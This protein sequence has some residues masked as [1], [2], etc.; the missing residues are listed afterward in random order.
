MKKVLLSFG[1]LVL[2]SSQQSWAT[3][4]FNQASGMYEETK[5]E[6]KDFSPFWG[7]VAIHGGLLERIRF[8]GHYNAT[9][10]QQGRSVD[11]PQ[12]KIAELIQVLFPSRD[13]VQFV[14]NTNGN[15]TNPAG[16]LSR[17][18]KTINYIIEI[19]I[20]ASDREKKI[21]DIA[22][23][24]K[25][26][27][28]NLKAKDKTA[29]ATLLVSAYEAQQALAN[30][31]IP[32][33]QLYPKNIV[34]ISLLAYFCKVADQKEDLQ[35]LPVLMKENF[36]TSNLF[37]V[38]FDAQTYFNLR[39]AG[40]AHLTQMIKSSDRERIFLMAKGHD[41][42]EN[43]ILDGINY[44]GDTFYK[45]TIF[46]D[47]GETSL[48]NVLMAFLGHQGGALSVEVL[49]EVWKKITP[50][51]GV[52]LTS[53][54]IPFQRM[55]RF[56]ES[57]P[58]ITQ[59]STQQVHEDWAKVVADLNNGQPVTNF[60]DVQY[61]R[62]S[63][64]QIPVYEIKSNYSEDAPKGI[65]NM[66]NVVAKLI[67]DQILN[68][69]W[70]NEKGKRFKQATQKLNRLCELF[71]RNGNDLSWRNQST[72]NQTIDSP[73]PA[74]L[75]T[76][77]SQPVYEWKFIAGHFDFKKVFSYKDDWRV[78]YTDRNFFENEWIA[79]LFPISPDSF[80]R[81]SSPDQ[82]IPVDIVYNCFLKSYYG[83]LNTINLV[84]SNHL[85]QFGPL[86]SRWIDLSI[87]FND[88]YA[89]KLISYFL[90]PWTRTPAVSAILEDPK[91]SPISEL[92]ATIDGRESLAKYYDVVGYFFKEINGQYLLEVTRNV[93]SKG[94][95]VNAVTSTKET[96]LHYVT[97]NIRNEEDRLE[98]QNLLLQAGANVNA[99]DIYDQTPLH[100][101][102][103]LP[104]VETFLKAGADVNAKTRSDET[105]L[106]TAV[107]KRNMNLVK[108]FLKAGAN[109][110]T[111]DKKRM[112]PLAKAVKLG[113]KDITRMLLQAGANPNH[114]IN[115]SSLLIEAMYQNNIPI[116]A[117]LI[118][119]GADVNKKDLEGYPPISSAI[120]TPNI[121]IL[122][123]LLD[124]GART[125]IKDKDGFTAL[126]LLEDEKGFGM[127][128]ELYQEMATLLSQPLKNGPDEHG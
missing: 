126:E 22:S 10:T 106:H 116:V 73:F 112:T 84:L 39:R 66:L 122:K 52:N 19:L 56:F 65:F 89:Q 11:K 34:V 61:G 7:M 107:A 76:I 20:T 3:I 25:P 98:I 110:D 111:Q 27:S 30:P 18:L 29:F 101:A 113:E 26:L 117:M 118:K 127:D 41:A 90:Y 60:N 45:D 49:D 23:T 108:L 33:H 62:P 31:A 48:R 13:G 95:D 125:D 70:D 43:P 128:R 64:G 102:S 1:L 57:Y 72:N 75:L 87:P 63:N 28:K 6:Y 124:H 69:P 46:P 35:N 9:G 21:S 54:E 17:N 109:V 100:Q 104:E 91:F 58:S 68:M 123:L 78:H 15:A 16:Y 37:R 85:T 5:D 38:N 44:R 99:K 96:P 114:E 36:M 92:M 82:P 121:T 74:L 105:P 93:L 77:H 115:R 86:L 71:S 97:K 67:P 42:Y 50:I 81:T 55:K 88:P 2:I 103:S 83:A 94:A 12:D 119:A 32:Q 47:C 120:L 79:S 8:F 24:L 59:A 80:M 51:P 14:A 40:E 4:L 53:S